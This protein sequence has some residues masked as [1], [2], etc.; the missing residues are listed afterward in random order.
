[1][2][3]KEQERAAL[4]ALLLL[5]LMLSSSPTSPASSSSPKPKPKAPEL[6]ELVPE[7]PAW[8]DFGPYGSAEESRGPTAASVNKSAT[9]ARAKRLA[10]TP[11]GTI[12]ASPELEKRSHGRTPAG[13]DPALARSR[14]PGIAAL[15]AK[16]GPKAYD[17]AQLRAW[18]TLAGLRA[19][20]AY[21][22]STRGALVYYGVTDPPRPFVAPLAT[23]PYVPPEGAIANGTA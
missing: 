15:L 1:M 10:K 17:R 5:A 19:D 9:R 22:G 20:G 8:P 11:S 14:A 7:V 21:G 13:Y 2:T 3:Q 18:Q 16:K 12:S 6:P 4:V 23:L